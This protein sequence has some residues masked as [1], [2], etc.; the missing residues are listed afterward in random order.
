MARGAAWA[1]L[2]L[3]ALGA[4]PASAATWTSGAFHGIGGFP[5]ILPSPAAPDR[6][7]L[8]ATDAPGGAPQSS[9]RRT[10]P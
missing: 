1:A 4:A 3:A 6:V 10:G 2:A 7:Y 9:W 5:E 8:L